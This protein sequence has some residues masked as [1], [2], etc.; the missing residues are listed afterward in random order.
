MVLCLL[1]TAA[2]VTYDGLFD[3]AVYRQDVLVNELHGARPVGDLVVEV[4]SQT[5]PLQLQLFGLEGGF[6]RRL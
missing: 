5:G 3:A 1:D 2:L 6:H 4:V